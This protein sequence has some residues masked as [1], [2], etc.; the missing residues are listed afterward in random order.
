MK[1]ILDKKLIRNYLTIRYNPVDPP[2]PVIKWTNLLNK[3]SDPNGLKTE[4]LLINSI[5]HSNLKN[6]PTIAIS[7][8]SGID[9]TL[10][11]GLLRKVFPTKNFIS[12]CAVFSTNFDESKIARKIAK[13]FES[14]FKVIKIDS[15]FTRMPELVAITKKPRWN[16][17]QHIIAKEASKFSKIL[18]TG[19][20]ADEIFGGYTFRYHKFQ[21]LHK[22]NSNWKSRVLNYLE[23]HNRDWVPDQQIMF[24]KAVYFDWKIIYNYL[25]PYFSNKLNFLE[26][27]MLADFNGKLLFD[28]IP[29]GKIIC[30]HYGIKGIPI[31]LDRNVVD[32]GLR[33]PIE[34]K[35]DN[36]NQKGKLVLRKIAK[37][38]GIDHIDEKKGFSPDLMIDWNNRGKRICEK[39]ILDE[40]SNI[41]QKKLIRY[42][43]VLKA[44]EK[45]EDDGDIRYLNR[46][47]SILAL[48]IWYRV[49]ISKQ[50]SPNDKLN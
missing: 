34:Q 42:N 19:D 32:F 45:I 12:I 26:Q 21:S 20:G 46:I 1:E 50:I 16:T 30:K 47:I 6:E 28:F 37:R 44:L 27:L 18:V 33:L 35:Y 22:P 49:F 41:F 9:S 39:Y 7:L 43:W 8:S 23:C 2:F 38:L 13:K 3:T 25:K 4:N 17:Y 40:N 31:F 36:S 29:T 14:E 48:E 15:I 10:C 5:K 11:L 24:G